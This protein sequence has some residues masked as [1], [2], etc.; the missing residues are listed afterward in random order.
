MEPLTRGSKAEWEGWREIEQLN[1]RGYGVFLGP[2]PRSRQQGRR[3]DV[4]E[5]R[6][7]YADLDVQ[8]AQHQNGKHATKR[9]AFLALA[10]RLPRALFPSAIV[11][12]GN[13]L[14]AFWYVRQPIPVE[15]EVGARVEDI[16]GRLATILDGDPGAE[17]NRVMRFPGSWNMKEPAEPRPVRLVHLAPYHR[18]TLEDFE[19]ILASGDAQAAS[20]EEEAGQPAEPDWVT[21]LLRGVAQG[22]RHEA[23]KRLAGHFLG[24]GTS[25]EHALEILRGW[26]LRCAPP[27]TEAGAEDELQVIVAWAAE[28]EAQKVMTPPGP[29]ADATTVLVYVDGLRAAP[30]VPGFLRK[31][32]T[33]TFVLD[34]LRA[35]GR[36]LR[37]VESPLYFRR[38]RRRVLDLVPGGEGLGGLL[39]RFGLN[40][41]EGEF[42]YV[43]EHLRTEALERGEACEVSHLARYD[44]GQQP[45]FLSRFDGRILRLDGQQVIEAENGEG[46]V[47]FKDE[48]GWLPWA[49]DLTAPPGRFDELLIAPVNFTGGPIATE[50]ARCMWRLWILGLFFA[51]FMKTKPI[52]LLMG[53]KGAGKTSALRAILV[54]LLGPRWKGIRDPCGNQISIVRKA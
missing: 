6:A 28:Q 32:M 49:A 23:A 47:Y 26:A 30:K 51:E 7:L 39:E 13:G 16:Q 8:S 50:D 15:G 52:C 35:R 25:P 3:E 9:A 18:F 20:H 40:P 4:A 17:L 11:D 38:D 14:Q 34:Q 31:R 37:A 5:V 53:P 33:A 12:S 44:A 54:A 36:F 48:P 19:P 2:N 10:E 41:T 22:E 24:T 43:A 21:D 1:G 29:E 42:K 45:L 27:W 46:G